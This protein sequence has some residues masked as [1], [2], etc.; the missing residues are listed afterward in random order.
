MHMENIATLALAV[1]QAQQYHK[2]TNSYNLSTATTPHCLLVEDQP[3]TD[4]S[5]RTSNLLARVLLFQMV[6]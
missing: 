6:A 3:A 1:L 5:L 4:V 2:K